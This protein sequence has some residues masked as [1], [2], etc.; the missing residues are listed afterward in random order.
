[1]ATT[2]RISRIDLKDIG[3]SKAV[4][5]AVSYF[6]ISRIDLKAPEK[7]VHSVLR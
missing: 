7:L 6:G 4:R 1:M 3:I 2:H 5:V